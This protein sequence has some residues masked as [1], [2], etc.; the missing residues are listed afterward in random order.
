M[1]NGFDL[2]CWGSSWSPS[3]AMKE[4]TTIV[5]WI[6]EQ[7]GFKVASADNF[8]KALLYLKKFVQ[9]VFHGEK[10]VRVKVPRH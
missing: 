2:H 8:N 4:G 5:E 10:I 1:A 6:I 7:S 9:V 3:R